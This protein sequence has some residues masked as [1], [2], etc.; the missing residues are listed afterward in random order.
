MPR[1]IQI[2]LGGLAATGTSTIGK[3]LAQ[4]L[5]VEFK[6]GGGFC[7]QMA[8]SMGKDFLDFLAF[9][10]E[11]PWVDGKIDDQSVLLAN[12][13]TPFVLESRLGWVF[14]PKSF[15]VLLE[16]RDDVRFERIAARENI[17]V[18]EARRI[19]IERELADAERYQKLYGIADCADPRKFD[20]TVMTHPDSVDDC[21][22]R[23]VAA[24][25]EWQNAA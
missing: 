20:L 24:V 9:A 7:R 14:A 11:N 22:K 2:T 15:K 12:S 21:L 4:R 17:A 23:I 16:C 10:K 8:A 19:T 6:S 1:I 5:K 13:G 3:L 18:D 25:H